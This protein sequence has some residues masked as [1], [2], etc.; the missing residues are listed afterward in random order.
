[1]PAFGSGIKKE[2]WVSIQGE[3]AMRDKAK[4]ALVLH[5]KAQT[6]LEAAKRKAEAALVKEGKA[7]KRIPSL[8][9]HLASVSR[10]WGKL[11]L[12][13]QE[14]EPRP[15]AQIVGRQTFGAGDL[16]K[17]LYLSRLRKSS[18][19]LDRAIVRAEKEIRTGKTSKGIPLDARGIEESRADLA[20]LLRTK[21][22]TEKQIAKLHRK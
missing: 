19:S 16:D 21:Q 3:R 8:R 15:N 11:R 4:R 12:M 2:L 22:A 20:H 10:G 9:K 1:M 14:R 7:A 17:A 13:V 18:S 5:K 6:K